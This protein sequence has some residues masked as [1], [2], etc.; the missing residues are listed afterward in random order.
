[1]QFEHTDACTT[2]Q[3]TAGE[4]ARIR[5]LL[6]L[7]LLLLVTAVGGVLAAAAVALGAAS[8]AAADGSAN[9]YPANATCGPNSTAGSCRANIEWR[10]SAYGPAGSTQVRRRE[11]IQV[12]AQAGEV[13]EMGS[14]AVGVN[15]GDVTVWN[16]GVVTNAN[17][18]PLPA[19]TSGTN[20]FVCSAQRAGSGIAG[21]GRITTRALELAGPRAV[22]GGGNPAGYIPC[23][24]TAPSTGIYYVAFY[25][26]AGDGQDTDGAPT[27][28]INLAGAGNFDATQGTSVAA[29]DITVRA[30]ATATANIPGRVFSLAF[31]A[32]TGG[33]GRPV[34]SSIDIVT[35]D[36]YRYRTDFRGVDPN[37]FAFYGNEA[38]FFDADGTTP[39]NHDA[40]A[41]TNSGQLTALAGGVTFAPP[42]YPVFF[43]SPADQTLTA[44]GIPTTAVAPNMSALSFAGNVA[45]NTSALGAGGTFS[46]TSNVGG[47]YQL[48]ISRD[49]VN[50]DPGASTN[51]V[52]RGIRGAGTQSVTWDGKDNAGNNFPVGSYAVHATLESGSFHFP[53]LDAENSTLGGPTLTLLNPPGAVC[54]FANPACTTG[55][56]DDRGYHTSAGIN[57]GTSPPP[58]TPL[59]GGSPPAAPYHSDPV[60]GFLTTGIARA[61]GTDTGGNANVPCNGSFGDV[62]GLDLWTF[63]PSSVQSAP[64]NVVQGAIGGYIY[65]DANANGTKD[66]GEAGYGGVTVTLTQG[67]ATIATTTTDTD[68]SYVFSGLP[69]GIYAVTS[70][71]PGATTATTA[72]P[73]T[74]VL[75]VAGQ[76]D[77]G[78]NIGFHANDA[79][80]SGF[81][82]ND[83]NANGTKDTGEGGYNALTVTLTKGAAT[84]ATTTT[85][86]DGSYS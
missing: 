79:S 19:V 50:F 36:G 64:L 85:A 21:Q 59:C 23:S 84:V 25:G 54:P 55:F 86:P 63:Y 27:A 75:L 43:T 48:I 74:P 22:S 46:Y 49:G 80:I 29:W 3:D 77:S 39:L 81:V 26:P 17:A 7:L 62:K 58:D 42:S 31:V 11:L 24:Y 76:V 1:M 37:G 41:T 83:T 56:N 70:A 12:Y 18:V 72:N 4:R 30:S 15:S 57:V 47:V 44:V 51:R 45:G 61:Y 66:A 71:V 28:D 13:L 69:A 33:N 10:T 73:L 52:L 38:G 53:L 20:G 67:S 68:G 34:N 40:Y 14:S 2:H 16:P 5:G 32:F 35:T 78:E 8:P 9:L 60:N 6:R 65:N 82:F